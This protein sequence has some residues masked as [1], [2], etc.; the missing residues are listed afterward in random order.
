MVLTRSEAK[1]A[2]NHVLDNVLGRADGTPLKSALNSEN[3]TDIFQLCTL[4]DAVIDALEYMDTNIN[5]LP[6]KVRLGDKM[7]LKVFLQYI[8]MCHNN[9]RPIGDDWTQITQDDFDS[10][11]IDPKYYAPSTSHPLS[12]PPA[13]S[14]TRSSTSTSHLLNPVELFRRGIK[15]DATLFPTLKDDKYHDIWHQSFKTQATAQAV[16]EVLDEN[17]VPTGA[18]DI[19]LFQEKQKYVYAVLETKVMTDRGK[20]IIRDHEHDFDAQKAYQKIKAYH[21]Q[22]TKA[23]M[24]SS[25]ILSYI[26]SAK[27]G[28]GTWN[29]TTEAF[30]IHW[31]NQVRL[32]EKH[33]PPSD[34]F[35][36]GQK[37][38]ML[39]N[40][41]HGI[42]ELRQVKNTA[43][44]MGANSGTTLTYDE[45]ASLLLSA[46]TAYDDQ[47]KAKKAKRH[48]MLHD[49]QH[50]EAYPDIDEYSDDNE[51]FDIDCPVSSIQ[52]YA[53]NFRSTSGSKSGPRSN[54]SKVRMS[55]DK[56][57][58]LS[59]SSK[60]IWDRLDE[61]AKAIILGYSLPTASNPSTAQ[62]RNSLLRLHSLV[63]HLHL[64]H[65]L[66]Y[67]RFLLMIFLWP[68]YTPLNHRIS[69]VMKDRMKNQIPQLL[70]SHM[71]HV[72][73][74]LLKLV[75]NTFLQEIFD[76]FM[77]KST[78]RHINLAH[79][80]Y[81]VSL[82][83]SL[84]AK[85]LSLI[86]RGANGG[87]AGEDVRIIFRT[88]RNVDIKGIDNHHVNDIGI[89]TVGG[90]VP[91][92]TRV[93]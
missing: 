10:F 27:L 87:V 91:D 44:Q 34:H 57:F 4:T 59:D 24:E 38:V 48:V 77:S 61:K 3:I 70:M 1:V 79:I 46:A 12:S 64:N 19:A 76:V 68:M 66:I 30:I 73:S 74:M 67:T 28:E 7:L 78:N 89:G 55:S 39:Q 18:D 32:Y 22:S 29:G 33:V 36:D 65:K 41:V 13:A 47:F 8:S 71:T 69:Q 42:N 15:R 53:T 56:W 26:T 40:S 81:R 16:S 62:P 21:L 49:F 86:D 45:Y 83:D 5:T 93:Q 43:D 31:Q 84:T 52:A 37:R 54:T 85:S 92:P 23:K 20:A 11:R 63:L 17:Y 35:S 14:G 90:V 51:I 2:F 9:G 25:V 58:S 50:D 80:E 82:H 72:L 6:I 60:A 88:N 75:V